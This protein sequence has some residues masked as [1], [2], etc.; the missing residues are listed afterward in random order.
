MLHDSVHAV[1]WATNAK[2]AEIHAAIEA[3]EANAKAL[4]EYLNSGRHVRGDSLPSWPASQKRR[5]DRDRPP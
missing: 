1:A 5:P 2:K 4:R 3:S